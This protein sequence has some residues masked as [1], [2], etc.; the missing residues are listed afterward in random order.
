MN[1]TAP[2]L[3]VAFIFSNLVLPNRS[4]SQG[5]LNFSNYGA[6]GAIT[7]GLTGLPAE[8]G[9]T[10]SVALYFAQD[11]ISDAA[12][13]VQIGPAVHLRFWAGYFDGGTYRVPTLPAGGFGMFQVRVW[14]TAFGSTY[15]QA[16]ASS[17]PQ[18][19]RLGLAGESGILRGPTGNPTLTEPTPPTL[20]WPFPSVA[21]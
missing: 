2:F 12:Q 7:N 20:L 6:P 18:N 9:T 21:A 17:T 16:V 13:L 3:A 1:N 5:T 4:S 10:F 14:E 19:G 11:G 8:V 15:E